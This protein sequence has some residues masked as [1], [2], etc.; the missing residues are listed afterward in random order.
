VARLQ[1]QVAI[2]TGAGSG[3]G[4]AGA[5]LFAREGARVVVAELDQT[6]GEAVAAGIRD[7]GGE[8]LF[9]PCDVRDSASVQAMV[10]ATV[11]R[12]GG[13]DVLYHNA[14][15][16]AFVNREDRCIVDLP[17]AVW[18]GMQRIALTGA[19]LCAK[20]AALAMRARRRGSIVL[21]ATVDALIG[22]AGLDAYTAAKGG[23]VAM[24]RSMAAGLARDGIR[25]NTLCPGFVATESQMT[26]LG[27]ETARRSI[28]QL[29]LLP[30]PTPED[31]APFALFL[32]SDEARCVTGGIFPVDAGYSAF[33]GAANVMEVIKDGY[34]S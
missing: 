29:H 18:D 6:R 1:D 21:T 23:V 19:F 20:Y 5:Q 7:T 34:G 3:I 15:D 11:E 32:A 14:I 25:V 16:V 8:A 27:D 4:R 26:W 17:E 22:Q 12:W 30:L 33:K 28:E 13:L 24:T 2:V 10:A 31:I 9:V